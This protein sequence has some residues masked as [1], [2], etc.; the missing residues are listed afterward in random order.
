MKKII[1]IITILFVSM[2]ITNSSTETVCAAQAENQEKESSKIN[3]PDGEYLVE[4]QLSGGS[5]RAFVTSPATLYVCEEEAAV[6]IEWSS[7]YYDYMTL[8]GETYYP[9]NTE[10]NSVFELPVTAFD[11]EIAVTADTTAM[12][13]PHEI[14]YTI[15]LVGDSIEKRE[16]KSMEVVAVIYIAAVIAAGTIAWCVFRKRRKQ[17]NE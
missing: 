11:T 14:D 17:K 1:S 6:E 16:E 8:D 12:S 4:V 9:V 2:I 13:V 3:L 7:P 10:G 15:C 5:G